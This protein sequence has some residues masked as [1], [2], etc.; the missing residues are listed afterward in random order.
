MATRK[1]YTDEFKR[2][3]VGMLKARGH[4]SVADVADDLGVNA[5][6]LHRWAKQL[7]E[8]TPAKEG[9]SAEELAAEVKRL[10][11]Q[12]EKLETEKA[13]LKKAA[14]FFAKENE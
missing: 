8:Q 13:I 9:P 4:R 14:A 10:R 1:R 6:Q 5:G 7:G 11:K 2:R 3:A 12:V